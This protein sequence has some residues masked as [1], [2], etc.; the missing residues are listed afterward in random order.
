VRRVGGR[1]KSKSRA[2]A[3]GHCWEKRKRED[4]HQ[5]ALPFHPY[6]MEEKGRKKGFVAE[7]GKEKH[8]KLGA[9]KGSGGIQPSLYAGE[10]RELEGGKGGEALHYFGGGK[11]RGGGKV[12]GCSC[13]RERFGK[14]KGRERPDVEGADF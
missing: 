3:V 7:R 8:K 6:R 1:K 2:L 4:E 14:G 5:G 13:R 12:S 11:K 10:K 9:G